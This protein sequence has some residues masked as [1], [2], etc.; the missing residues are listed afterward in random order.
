M[1]EKIFEVKVASNTFSRRGSQIT[2]EYSPL[3]PEWQN[4][5]CTQLCIPFVKQLE[6]HKTLAGKQLSKFI[7]WLQEEKIGDGNCL[8]RCMSTI[9]TG[10]QLFHKKL[11]Q[12]LCR[13]VLTDGSK[14]ML[15][16]FSTKYK[17]TTTPLQ[18]LKSTSMIT[19]GVYA[20]DVE[21]VAISLLLKT[22]I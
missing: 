14:Y 2:P 10:S 20:T 4:R 1:E 12:E 18:Y 3:S 17:S 15:G 16:Y 11:R 22:D 7:P 19:D 8:F 5:K 6:L 9:L 21:I 13:Y